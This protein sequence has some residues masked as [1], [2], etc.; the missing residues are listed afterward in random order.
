[1]Y[2]RSSGE[3]NS[4]KERNLDDALQAEWEAICREER[5]YLL[6][7]TAEAGLRPE[8][9]DN[10]VQNVF[11]RLVERRPAFTGE[12]AREQL[13]HWLN[14][15][16]HD[17]RMNLLRWLVRHPTQSLDALQAEPR[18]RR[19]DDSVD[20]EQVE[21]DRK[22]MNEWMENLRSDD[23]TNYRLL[24]GRYIEQRSVAELAKAEGLTPQAVSSRLHRVLAEFRS[25]AALLRDEDSAS[26]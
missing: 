21:G 1:M 4:D 22:L 2:E 24:H 10:V 14:K 20:W 3:S 8:L 7:L 9:A 12:D 5:A 17:E 26:S 18:D 6:E 15:V 23:P 25:R 13:R 16:A 19:D 11:L